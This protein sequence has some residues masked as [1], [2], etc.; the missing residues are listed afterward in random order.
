MNLEPDIRINLHEND[1]EIDYENLFSSLNPAYNDF[2]PITKAKYEDIKKLL[3]YVDLPTGST[4]YDEK[5]LKF[6]ISDSNTHQNQFI[7]NISSTNS[8]ICNS[9][10]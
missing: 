9:F 8:C 10:T 4:F 5:H 3:S 1:L 6:K 2:L 7:S